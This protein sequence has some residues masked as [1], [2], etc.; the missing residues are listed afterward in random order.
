[1][2]QSTQGNNSH[3]H[4]AYIE[5]E[6]SLTEKHRKALKVH[7]P[8]LVGDTETKQCSCCMYRNISQPRMRDMFICSLCNRQVCMCCIFHTKGNICSKCLFPPL[9]S[10]CVHCGKKMLVKEMK[11]IAPRTFSCC[12][13]NK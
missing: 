9:T 2:A 8:P 4:C 3:I 1:M 10:V 7:F 11:C 13:I 12:V 6:E 5:K